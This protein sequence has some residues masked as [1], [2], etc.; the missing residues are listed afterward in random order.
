VPEVIWILY[1][2]WRLATPAAREFDYLTKI[3]LGHFANRKSSVIIRSH[4][5][6]ILLAAIVGVALIES[7]SQRLLLGA[8][9]S[10][11]AV[12]TMQLLAFLIIFD[13]RATRLV[14][15]IALASAVVGNWA[16]YVLPADHLLV[17]FR[18]TYHS[19]L[20]LLFGF[21]TIVI[22]RDILE[23]RVVRA[24]DVLGAVCGYLLAAGAWSNLF[25]LTEIVVPG[26]FAVGQGFGVGLDSWH[27]RIA[28]L[29]YVSLGSL[30][31]AASGEVV[32][33]LPPATVLTTLEAVFGQFYI[34]VVVAQ[35]VG[36]RLSQSSQRDSPPKS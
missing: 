11:L 26:S 25:M 23:R 18:L 35:L 1:V 3:S 21:A 4:K 9:L 19:A 20:L 32:P 6:A 2:K 5:H 27:G 22:L 28:V 12:S 17:P 34:A 33:V 29:N 30:T 10:D 7:F 16:H 8:V 36:A 14:A 15:F 24:D 31:T 13:R